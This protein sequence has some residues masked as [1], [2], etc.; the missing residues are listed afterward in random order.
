M[1]KTSE[2]VR[3]SQPPTRNSFFGNL[4]LRSN[5]E[6]FG[7]GY[8]RF[9]E[10]LREASAKCLPAGAGE[11]ECREFYESL[12]LEELALARACADGLEAAWEAFLIRYRQKLYEVAAYIAK[13]ASAGR[14]LADNLYAD[15]YGTRIREGQRMCKLTSY[16]GRG[17]LEGWLRTVLA[18]EYVN[19]YRKQR[20]YVS[21]DEESEDGAQFAVAEAE[22]VLSIDPR[23]EPAIDEA[24]ASLSPEDRFVLASYYLDE[25]TLA[26]IARALRV[27][28]STISRRLDKLAKALRKQI[29]AGLTKRGMSRRQ[30]LEA[31]EVDVRDLQLNIRRHL[32]QEGANKSFSKRK[33]E[34]QTGEGTG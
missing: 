28:E 32:A 23:M 25:R 6:K 27:H 10:I 24:L 30:A 21:L 31:M 26:D 22:P 15:L 12:K 7:L 29:L 8:P 13:E 33:T 20:R 5:A 18:Q 3:Q 16:M 11:L 4:Y 1:K 2:S 34:A 9:V 17:S 14:E 19:R